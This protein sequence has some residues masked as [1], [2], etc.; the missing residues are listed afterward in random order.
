MSIVLHQLIPGNTANAGY[1][2]AK[3]LARQTVAQFGAVRGVGVGI[4]GGSC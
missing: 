2:I 3:E 4:G 1:G